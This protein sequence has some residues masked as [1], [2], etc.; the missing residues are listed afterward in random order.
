MLN[1]RH[2][3]E[4]VLH[5]LLLPL[6][7]DG[8]AVQDAVHADALGRGV[9]LA[10]EALVAVPCDF[11]N[12]SSQENTNTYAKVKLMIMAEGRTRKLWDRKY[13]RNAGEGLTFRLNQV[14]T[15]RDQV[16]ILSRV[17]ITGENGVV[18]CRGMG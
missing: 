17:L 2:A 15:V 8:H 7:D 16:Y 10:V 4:P 3:P 18:G 11:T 9:R 13:S 5:H 14:S 1:A 6:D 12:E